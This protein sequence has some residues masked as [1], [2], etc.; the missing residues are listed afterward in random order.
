VSD[1]CFGNKYFLTLAKWCC[2][3]SYLWTLRLLSCN[4]ELL[5]KVTKMV[6]LQFCFKDMPL[7]MFLLFLRFTEPAWIFLA[8]SFALMESLKSL[9]E[10]A[11]SSCHVVSCRRINRSYLSTPHR[12]PI[13]AVIWE[14]FLL[15]PYISIFDDDFSSP[16]FLHAFNFIVKHI[17]HRISRGFA[18]HI[19]LKL[20][21]FNCK[22]NLAVLTRIWKPGASISCL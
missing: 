6:F 9:W 12:S 10:S 7:S 22:R 21:F 11:F 5:Q 13:S 8:N 18:H 16:Y 3:L 14:C 1:T 20:F 4:I 15:F 19:A 2:F 17:F